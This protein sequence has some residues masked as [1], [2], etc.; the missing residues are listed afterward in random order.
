MKNKWLLTISIVCLLVFIGCT[1]N[2]TTTAYTNYGQYVFAGN[3]SASQVVT[4]APDTSTGTATFNAVYDAN[5][6]IFNYTF[7]WSG[8]TNVVTGIN[9]YGPADSGQV[10]PVARNVATY[11]STQY[12]PTTDSLSS[13]IWANSRLSNAELTALKKGQWYYA[14]STQGSPA[15][16]EVRGQIKL[17][18]STK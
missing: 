9:I 8:L 10:G 15:T 1:K 6:Q 17:V 12:L 5:L 11:N 4:T 16:G 3:G 14:I 7:K 18:D 13:A 2:D